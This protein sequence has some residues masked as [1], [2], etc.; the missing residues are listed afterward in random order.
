ME[1]VLL[2]LVERGLIE[3]DEE[4]IYLSPKGQEL[5]KGLTEGDL[6]RLASVESWTEGVWFDL[7]S[8]NI[9]T[10]ARFRQ[11]PNLL[12]I[13]DQ[14]SARQI[15][16]SFAR[17]AFE[18][19]FHDYARRVRRHPDADR[20]AIYSVSEVEAG[21]Y[22]YQPKPAEC[23]LDVGVKLESSLRMP[24]AEAD[25]ARFAVLSLAATDAWAMLA[26]PEQ[27]ASGLDDYERLTG[28]ERPRILGQPTADTAAWSQ[29]FAATEKGGE[30]LFFGATYLEHNIAG[31]C[32][33][34]ETILGSRPKTASSSIIWLRPGGTAWGRT[35]KVSESL[36]RM[37][38]VLRAHGSSDIQT[39]AMVPRAVAG[40]QRK[41]LKRVFETGCLTPAGFYPP[42]LEIILVPGVAAM[43]ALHVNAGRHG[44]AIGAVT[45]RERSLRLMERR[46]NDAVAKNSDRLWATDGNEQ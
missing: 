45:S 44:V 14:P 46:F 4:E 17:E 40:N 3:S 34:M 1:S 15:P 37:R 7:I 28:D 13:R 9:M 35:F 31:L 20:L 42:D 30:A 29:A 43:V 38:D 5:F 41:N 24:F 26:G 8:R 21:I 19:N 12:A 10:P 6:P 33:M 2:E 23:V 22:G 16:E 36:Q 27:S 18:Q 11:L 32:K 39:V 25:P